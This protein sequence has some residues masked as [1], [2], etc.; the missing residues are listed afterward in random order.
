MHYPAA[1]CPSFRM[2]LARRLQKLS[3]VF[4]YTAT[5]ICNLLRCPGTYSRRRFS[6]SK[7]SQIFR[8]WTA[9]CFRVARQTRTTYQHGGSLSHVLHRDLPLI[10]L[11]R[12][13]LEPSTAFAITFEER[14]GLR[15]SVEAMAIFRPPKV[16]RF[17]C[18]RRLY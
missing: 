7:Q 5:R 8:I 13:T 17:P 18:S 6:H 4:F 9:R 11:E 16:C 3:V 15:T 10:D 12:R 2:S 1:S 14:K